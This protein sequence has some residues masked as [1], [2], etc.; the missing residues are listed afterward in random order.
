MV[1]CSESSA[2]ASSYHR[3]FLHGGSPRC[4]SVLIGPNEALGEHWIEI[5]GRDSEYTY[6][7]S[8]VCEELCDNKFND[9]L[10]V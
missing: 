3:A 10:G 4:C 7:D 9:E 2:S 6:D 5:W 8:E 1:W